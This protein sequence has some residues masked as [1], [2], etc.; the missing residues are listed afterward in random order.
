MRLLPSRSGV[1]AK[2]LFVSFHREES[3]SASIYIGGQV[4]LDINASVIHPDDMVAQTN[5]AMDNL[6]RVLAEFDA[7]LDDVVKVTTFYQGSASA[8]ALHQNLLIRSR[9]YTPP[10]PVT[11]GNPVPALVYE[12]MVIEIEAIA[13][14]D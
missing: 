2:W 3:R 8:E 14:L 7:T 10:G 9:S 12:K 11:T 6:K 1:A 4:S 5:V 13:L